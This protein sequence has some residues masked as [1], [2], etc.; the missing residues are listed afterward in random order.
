MNGPS[1]GFERAARRDVRM[2]LAVAVGALMVVMAINTG[3]GS[4]PLH[5]EDAPLWMI[6]IF[7]ILGAGMAG[8]ALLCLIANTSRGCRV[9][10]AKDTLTWWQLRFKGQP[11]E[12]K[13]TIALAEISRFRVDRSGDGLT[14]SL[15]DIHGRRREEFNAESLPKDYDTWLETLVERHPHIQIERQ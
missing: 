12:G 4:G 2:W 14:I 1:L 9:D 3:A 6:L 15:F 13:H 11:L 7:G 5:V 8:V 10:L